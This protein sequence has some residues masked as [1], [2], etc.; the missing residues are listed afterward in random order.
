MKISSRTSA[1]LFATL[2]ACQLLSGCSTTREPPTHVPLAPYAA[3]MVRVVNGDTLVLRNTRNQNIHTVRLLGLAAPISG[4]PFSADA[5]AELR[6]LTENASLVATAVDRDDDG[7]LLVLLCNA[8][9]PFFHDWQY[10]ECEIGDSVNLSIARDGLAWA[11]AGP[12]GA[13]AIVDA[14]RTA[15]ADRIGI[16]QQLAPIPPWQWEALPADKKAAIRQS[17]FEARQR[18]LTG[19]GGR[20]FAG[21]VMSPGATTPGAGVQQRAGRVTPTVQDDDYYWYFLG[22]TQSRQAGDLVAPER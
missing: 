1:I 13:E 14:E 19:P 10:P 6:R 4:Q 11:H 2:V 3:V 20:G 18:A 21:P 5:T 15:R 9:Q 22:L 12:S 8:D 17:E 7:T 16:W